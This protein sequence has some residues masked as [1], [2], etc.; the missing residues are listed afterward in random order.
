MTALEFMAGEIPLALQADLQVRWAHLMERAEP[1]DA[2]W[3][4]DMLASPR[5]GELLKAFSCSAIVL[6]YAQRFPDFLP[7]LDRN[8]WL[9]GDVPQEQLADELR[10]GLSVC[11]NADEAA[12]ELR[13]FRIK[14]WMRIVWRDLTRLAV[15]EQTTEDLSV[16]ADICVQ[17]ALDFHHAQMCIEWGE[18]HSKAGVP[19]RMVVIGMGKLG[20]GELNLSSDIDLIFAYPESGSTQ[21]GPRSVDNQQFFIRLGQRL[22]KSLDARTADG[23]VFRVDMRL[24]PYGQSGPLVVSFDALMEYY[25]DQGRD[26]ERYAL[27][28]ARCMAGDDIAGAELMRDLRPFVYRRYLDFSAIES[29]RDMK[30]MIQREVARRNLHDNVKLGAGGIR[31]IEFIAQCFQLIRG[32]QEPDL[33]ARE[34]KS[35][36]GTLRDGQ[37]LPA[38]AVDELHQAYRFLRDVEHGIQ[39]WREEQTQQL[40]QSNEARVALAFAM[41]FVFADGEANIEGFEQCLAEHRQRVTHHFENFIAPPEDEDGAPSSQRCEHWQLLLDE[42]N[43]ETLT[44]ALAESGFENAEEAARRLILLMD[45]GAVKRMQSSGRERLDD[46]MPL[47]LEALSSAEQPTETLIRLI[48]LIEA[49]LRRTAYLV[50]LLEN[51]HALEHLVSLCDTSPWMARQL[52]A[53]P[54]LL[55]ELLNTEQL[56]HAVEKDGLRSELRQRLLRIDQDDL[57]AQMEALRYFRLA[58]VLR[59]AAAELSGTLP[60]MKVSDYLTNIAEV[61]LES[62]LEIAWQN[63]VSK[64]GNFADIHDARRH[65]IILGYGKMG[66][67][68]LSYGSDLDM[69]FVHDL[70]PNCQT[71]GER[72]LDGAVFMTRLGQRI[73]HILT[74]QTRMGSLYEV[75]MRLRP[76][77]NSGLLV[78]S[79]RAFDEYQHKE[80][81]TWEHQALV[82]ARVVA[83]DEVLAEKFTELRRSILGL[84]RDEALLRADVVQMRDKMR[85]QLLPKTKRDENN[86]QFDLKQGEGGIVDIEFMV[87]YAVLA[88]SHQHPPLSVYTDN[89]RILESLQQQGLFSAEDVDTLTEAY[90]AFRSQ[91]HRLSL[92]EQSGQV[93][94]SQLADERGAVER[95]WQQLMLE[96]PA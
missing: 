4:G 33:Q 13:R 59:V 64:H 40:P 6:D 87:Q 35:I 24:R 28:K 1:F 21:G 57:E 16:L 41:G 18:P 44:A 50:L 72:P 29:L 15:M 34:L 51:P 66:G 39:A 42:L 71:D 88:W 10:A 54:V 77:G 22:I 58:H 96:E 92:Q 12:A 20:A 67:I 70:P 37:Y 95:C 8:G 23:F 26:W 32:G 65:F 93:A 43:P 3:Y 80:A 47:F 48:P 53:H 94:D 9:L 52:S 11:Q 2:Q 83:G 74:A 30:A 78:S 68:E 62:V 19:Q 84:S 49:V 17:Q 91:A 85:T 75:D 14:Y 7:T 61:V 27:I 90:K 55:D 69:V 76:S 36:L 63:L 73:I 79:F 46:F 25:Q 45:G 31:E 89:I 5:R 81:W 56:Y 86:R 38:Q 82:R 60:L